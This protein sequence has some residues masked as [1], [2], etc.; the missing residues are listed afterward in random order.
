MYIS[1]C[2]YKDSFIFCLSCSSL[3]LSMVFLSR[4]FSVLIRAGFEAGDSNLPENVGPL[5]RFPYFSD[6]QFP[7]LDHGW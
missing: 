1:R 7:Y 6:P 3:F 5:S 2:S 4:H